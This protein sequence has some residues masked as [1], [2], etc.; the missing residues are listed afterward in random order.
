MFFNKLKYVTV[1]IEIEKVQKQ[2]YIYNKQ[3]LEKYRSRGVQ[4]QK[5][6]QLAVLDV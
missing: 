5:V 1:S 6:P 4:N 3:K 2:G